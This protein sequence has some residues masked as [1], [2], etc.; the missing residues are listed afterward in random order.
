MICVHCRVLRASDT[1][2]STLESVPLLQTAT[3]TFV[4][5]NLA[6]EYQRVMLPLLDLCNHKGIGSNTFVTK[7]VRSQDYE[8][9]A[10][11]PIK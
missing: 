10:T 4:F 5:P 8:M 6:K 7:D 9:V 1:C 2:T 3:Y 11:R